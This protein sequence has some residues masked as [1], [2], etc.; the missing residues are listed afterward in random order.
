VGCVFVWDG[1]GGLRIGSVRHQ[2]A[3]LLGQLPQLATYPNQPPQRATCVGYPGSMCMCVALQI[4]HLK[5]ARA[6]EAAAAQQLAKK[7]ATRRH[8][9]LLQDQERMRQLIAVRE[10]M[11]RVPHS[12]ITLVFVARLNTT[13][14]TGAKGSTVYLLD[15]HARQK[16][17]EIHEIVVLLV[18]LGAC[19]WSPAVC[20]CA[21]RTRLTQRLPGSECWQ[22]CVCV[23]GG[24]VR[25]TRLPGVFPLCSHQPLLCSPS[26][27]RRE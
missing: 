16:R 17:C 23:S 13:V 11:V 19:D 25:S 7:E 22:R 21:C 2:E 4:D 15:A 24:G 8:K 10:E 18:G 26:L 5:Q 6:A 14:T 20:M 9:A 3:S 12:D 27:T 1:G